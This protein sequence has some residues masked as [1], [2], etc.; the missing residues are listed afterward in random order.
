MSR[1]S[2][3]WILTTIP[4][5]I[6]PVELDVYTPSDSDTYPMIIFQHGF[7]VSIKEYETIAISLQVMF[8]L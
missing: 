8:L 1:V 3:Q 6:A 4:D 5:T 7:S 2:S